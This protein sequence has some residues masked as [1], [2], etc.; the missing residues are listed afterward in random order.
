MLSL[1][2]CTG[3]LKAQNFSV[4]LLS[5]EVNPFSIEETRSISFLN[6]NLQVNQTSG[7][8]SA[9]ALNTMSRIDFSDFTDTPLQIV[10]TKLLDFYPNPVVDVLNVRLTQLENLVGNLTI[11]TVDGKVIYNIQLSKSHHELSIN[12]SDWGQGIYLL[13]YES[14]EDRQVEKFI[15]K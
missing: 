3:L 5:G 7:E 14:G 10:Q 2:A 11:R 4:V 9:F 12:T 13:Y 15:K 1:I 8:Y 6:N